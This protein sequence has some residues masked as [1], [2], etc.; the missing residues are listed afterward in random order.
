MN[1]RTQRGVLASVALTLAGV[2]VAADAP[3]VSNAWAR[4][5]SPGAAVGAVYLSIEGA[6]RPD[7]L[8]GGASPRASSVELHAVDA[9]AGVTRMRPAGAMDIPAGGRVE[10]APQGT[11]LMLLG[12]TAPLRAGESLPIA[13]RF[14]H[15]GEIDIEVEVRAAT[16][17]N[18][19]V[20]RT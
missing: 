13:L 16:S 1:R 12:L 15:A 18:G 17:G 5:T 2:A 19:T 11:H 10:L 14:E 3:R 7:R 8:L 4:A 9:S 6:A 20:P